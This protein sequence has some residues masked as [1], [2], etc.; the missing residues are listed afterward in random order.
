MLEQLDYTV[1]EGDG[2]VSVCVV[3]EEGELDG[4][5]VHV[6]IVI[7]PG[8]AVESSEVFSN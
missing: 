2:E 3:L 8:S 4:I 6:Q 7:V 1:G 5:S